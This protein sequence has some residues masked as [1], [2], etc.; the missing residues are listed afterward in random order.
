MKLTLNSSTALGVSG[1]S[2][3]CRLVALWRYSEQ[4]PIEVDLVA[5]HARDVV[6]LLA[7]EQQ[8]LHQVPE[9]E[10]LRAGR[11][12]QIPQLVVGEHTLALQ[13]LPAQPDRLVA[14]ARGG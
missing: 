4:A 6:K 10:A 3:A 2:C 11:L 13:V 9:R 7:G 5:P 14:D 1:T 8:E 12:P